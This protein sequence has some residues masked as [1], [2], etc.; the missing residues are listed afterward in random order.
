VVVA[1]ASLLLLLPPRDGNRRSLVMLQE[2]RGGAE[3]VVN[4][5]KGPRVVESL[6]ILHVLADSSR[7][8][9]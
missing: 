2:N 5:V 7:S 1:E 8:L 9:S 3:K 6:A 4:D